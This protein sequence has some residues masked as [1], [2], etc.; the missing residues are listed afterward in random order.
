MV[1][2][3]RFAFFLEYL[4]L[5]FASPFERSSPLGLVQLESHETD[6]D[7]AP[8][9]I[10]WESPSTAQMAVG[11]FRHEASS[12][13]E[14]EVWATLICVLELIA[15]HGIY[16]SRPGFFGC[17]KSGVPASVEEASALAAAG[18]VRRFPAVRADNAHVKLL[19]DLR[20]QTDS[21]FSALLERTCGEVQSLSLRSWIA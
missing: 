7:A 20:E 18:M 5:R 21:E 17:T 3:S 2:E 6:P 14:D 11:T 8:I 9:S 4:Q 16:E 12:R 13:D 10:L 1:N 15:Q 19:G